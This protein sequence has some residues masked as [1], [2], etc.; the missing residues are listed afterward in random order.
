MKIREL[1]QHWEENAKGRLTK[2]EYA[3]HLMWSLPR[4]W[5]PSPKCTPSATLKNCSAS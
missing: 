5:R 1:A 2:T 3:I 4:G